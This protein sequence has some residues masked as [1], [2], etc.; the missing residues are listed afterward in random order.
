M[1]IQAASDKPDT[2]VRIDHATDEFIG[3]HL[4]EWLRQAA[5]D[6]INRVRDCFAAHR[7][8]HDRLEQAMAGLVPLDRFAEQEFA[9]A[10]ADLLPGDTRVNE[11]EWLEVRRRFN[12][13]PGIGLPTDEVNLV[14]QPGLLRLMQNFHAGATYYEG[15]GLV[16]KGSDVVFSGNVDRLVERCRE[17]D[18]GQR[19]Q[20]MLERFFSAG[21]Q[22]LLAQ[23]KRAGLSLCAELATLKGEL[24][25]EANQAIQAITDVSRATPT[26]PLVG[27]PGLFKMLGSTIADAL[28]IQLRDEQGLDRGVVLYLPS[29]T[30]QALHR[31]ASWKAMSLALAEKLKIHEYR[32]RFSQLVSL[33]ERA[34]FLGLL[35]DRLQDPE[36]DLELD[37]ATVHGDIFALMAARQIQG[38]KQDAALLL[39]TTANA[40]KAAAQA[41]LE[42]W[43]SLGLG[44]VN[45]AGLFVPAIGALLLGHLAVQVLSETCQGVAHWHRGHQHEALEHLLGVAETLAV[46]AAV[47]G[48]ITLVARGFAR[49]A[50]VDA[51]EPV[52][53]EDDRR[54]LWHADL[55]AFRSDP[56]Q[57][58]LQPDGRFS[59]GQRH[60]L[61]IDG[62]FYQI[63]QPRSD[64]PWRLRHPQGNGAHEPLVEFNGERSWRLRS[65]RPLEWDDSA[66][67]LDTLWPQDPP[68][69]SARVEQILRSARMDHF[70]LRGLLVEHR[71][72]PF[73][74]K[75][76][77]EH[78]AA[79]ERIDRLY[80]DLAAGLEVG[81][82]D[83]IGWCRQQPELAALQGEPLRVAL[84][85]Q[86]SWVRPRLF[87]Y[88]TRSQPGADPLLALVR[89]DFPGLP[90]AYAETVLENATAAERLTA[91]NEARL[92]L[93]WSIRAR[94]LLQLARYNRALEGLYLSNAY[95]D[96]AGELVIALLRRLPR[97]PRHINLELRQGSESGR[98]LTILDPQ[99]VEDGRT[100]MVYK[101]DGFR[102]YDHLGRELEQDV[103]APGT[104]FQA[105]VALL[106][107]QE[108]VALGCDIKEP[109][110]SLRQL[111][112]GVLP[113]EADDVLR[114][115]G[116]RLEQQRWFN[117]GQRLPDGR[118][119]Y[120]LSGR[121]SG[122]RL[123]RQILRERVRHLYWGFSDQQVNDYLEILLRAPGSAFDILLDQEQNYFRLDRTL[124]QWVRSERH[125]ARR[126]LR[127]RVATELRR[128]WRLQGPT[129]FGED[130]QVEGMLLDLSDCPVNNL[131]LL[132]PDSDFS[133]V[134]HLVLSG[135]NL[136]QVPEAFL[137]CFTGLRDLDLTGNRLQDVPFGLIHVRNL[138]V[139]RLADNLIR[140]SR[141]GADV[142]AALLEMQHLDLGF[143]PL[144]TLSLPFTSRTRL[145]VVLLNQCLL[146][147]WPTGL[148]PCTELERV[149]LR[150][151]QISSVP[152]TLFQMPWVYRGIFTLDG[153]PL[154][155]RSMQRLAAPDPE[156]ELPDWSQVADVTATRALWT[157]TLPDAQ[158]LQRTALWERLSALP[159]SEGFFAL[160]GELG[161][162]ADYQRARE[163]LQAQVWQ[164]LETLDA[165]AQ[166]REDLFE[167]A[168]EPRTCAD[169]V[170]D[171]FS[172][173]RIQVMV[174]EAQRAQGPQRERELLALGRR[175][176]R[177]DRL[178]QFARADI[179]ER[180]RAGRGV[181][182]IEVSLAYRIRLTQQLELPGQPANMLFEQIAQV[183]E[184]Q[185]QNAL[186]TVR[187][188]ENSPELA[189]NLSQRDFWRRY[190]EERYTATFNAIRA[191]FAERGS[192]LD[193]LADSLTSE[194]Y[195]ERWQLLV[196]E[197]DVTLDA[198]FQQ[199]T[200]EA[201]MRDDPA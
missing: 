130:G 197:R 92:P 74:L 118:V 140:V 194:Q 71:P 125:L 106:T 159:N 46:T 109:A 121:G 1:P 85:D 103:E 135:S 187:A 26:Q 195:Q 185:L 139:L 88:L 132:P 100:V 153:N 146:R 149:D 10:L 188:A 61:R 11:L 177:L 138:R 96:E 107:P 33:E 176:F 34:G 117:P 154:S 91:R 53:T 14:R 116:W 131:P 2:Q 178:E 60:W 7:Q 175:L 145:R 24:D 27:Y 196:R 66:R 192:Q 102:L 193:E 49:S 86:M 164:M 101:P 123:A 183:S 122:R 83:V 184:A 169:C 167:R 166:I 144:V 57:A 45:L 201:L 156:A 112:I 44:L 133:H 114:L 78:F 90:D 40:D 64:E 62:Q 172:Q 41:R 21:K 190:V 157:D 155:S 162:S 75:A 143:N 73:N 113:G 182:E 79:D 119:G 151:N 147:E 36:V 37:G 70:E 126:S 94:S 105:L 199:I 59:D 181:D 120:P 93:T 25:V 80:R 108:Q 38:A 29:D 17:L 115:L 56:A 4:P 18:L 87:Q 54:L 150:H 50:F 22:D 15:T 84:L 19:Y 6:Q 30:H 63:H 72:V 142:L 77:L 104:I 111:L 165:N 110:G 127:Y 98:L 20:A 95:S 170:A 161:N 81:D 51:L 158:R 8:A 137:R 9:K 129:V 28:V 5:P 97:W 191:E 163:T 134:T 168:N 31:H 68:L 200:E 128:S 148:E 67:M 124:T 65:Q 55:T 16:R 13:S 186:A 32:G 180:V 42:R 12:V 179:A 47:A 160:L 141:D 58:T 82:E 189:R 89:R 39:V 173:L 48:G 174:F 171:R 198:L 52:V 99:G 69:E 152:A 76:T 23:D 3:A 43:Q 136:E 35:G